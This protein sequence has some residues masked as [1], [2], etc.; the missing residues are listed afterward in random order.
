MIRLITHR[1]P[2][3]RGAPHFQSLTFIN[4]EAAAAAVCC[5]DRE[6]E[7]EDRRRDR[8]VQGSFTVPVVKDVVEDELG[9]IV[10]SVHH[11]THLDGQ[12]DGGGSTIH[13]DIRGLCETGTALSLCLCSFCMTSDHVV[14]KRKPNEH[15]SRKIS[16]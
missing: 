2:H 16:L 11:R 10:A 14:S 9:L 12:A 8:L 13:G 6:A 15:T 3:Q 7:A 5:V 4:L 1:E